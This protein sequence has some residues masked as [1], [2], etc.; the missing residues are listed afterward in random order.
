ML[1]GDDGFNV[2][3]QTVVMNLKNI[4]WQ[5]IKNLLH[6]ELKRGRFEKLIL[7]VLAMSFDLILFDKT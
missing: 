5:S 2:I 6:E 7:V 4:D 1:I 3:S